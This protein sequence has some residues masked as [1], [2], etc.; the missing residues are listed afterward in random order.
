MFIVDIVK[1]KTKKSPVK[2]GDFFVL[3]VF[4][5]SIFKRYCVCACVSWSL[6]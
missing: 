1:L 4:I 3:N 6:R 2:L 5:N